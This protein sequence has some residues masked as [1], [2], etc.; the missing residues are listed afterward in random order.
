M[1]YVLKHDEYE[2]CSVKTLNK[3]RTKTLKR[4]DESQVDFF[5]SVAYLDLFCQKEDR[6]PKNRDILFTLNNTNANK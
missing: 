1:I 3:L 4:Y 6:I 2:M 5:Q